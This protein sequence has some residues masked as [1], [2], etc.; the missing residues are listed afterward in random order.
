MSGLKDLFG[1]SMKGAQELLG[2]LR[3]GEAVSLPPG[4]TPQTLQTY[5]GLAEK[6]IQAGKDTLGVQAARKEAIDLLLKPGGK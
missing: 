6:A 2:R 3:G 1:K 5:R 4:V